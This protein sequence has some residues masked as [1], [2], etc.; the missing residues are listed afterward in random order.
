[1]A[2]LIRAEDQIEVPDRLPVIAL[3]DIV[4]FPYSVLPLL[5]GRSRSVTALDEASLDRDLILL[6]TQRDPAIDDPGSG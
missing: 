1:M 5:I 3:R 4:F 6:V 2:K